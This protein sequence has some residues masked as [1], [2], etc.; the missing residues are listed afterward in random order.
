MGYRD[1]VVVWVSY[2]FVFKDDARLNNL[3]AAR[4]ATLTRG[5]ML[6]RQQ[7]I[8]QTL[9]PDTA[10]GSPLC[11]QQ[12]KHLFNSTR[13]PAI[14][15]DITRDSDMATNGHIIVIRKNRFYVLECF[16]ANGVL[17]STAELETQFRRI[18]DSA[19]ADK[20]P[21]IGLL[22]SENRDSWTRIRTHLL[23]SPKNSASLDVIERAAFV[24]C[25]DDTTPIT[26][27]QASR[28]CW[29]GDGQNRFFDK[30]VQFIVF[31]NAKAGFCGEHSRMEA[32]A[33]SRLCDW[34]VSSIDQGKLDHGSPNSSNLAA[35]LQLSW[36]LNQ[37]SLFAITTAE[38]NFNKL[39]SSQKLHVV[40]YTTYGKSLIKT[41]RVSPDA[42]TQMAIQLAYYK[43]NGRVDA[44]YE[45]AQT[46]KFE[47]GRTETCRSVSIES[48][49]WVMAMGD[50]TLSLEKKCELGKRAIT[51]QSGYM[52]KCAEAH[53]VDRHL[54]GLKL[55]AGKDLPE[56]FKDPAYAK[57]CHWNLSTSQIASEH[58]DGYGWGEVVPDG[59]GC[60]YMVNNASLQFNLTCLVGSGLDPDVFEHYLGEALDEMKAAF[61][62]GTNAVPVIKAKL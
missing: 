30:S 4:A 38:Q 14:P 52:A 36:D 51:A 8:D 7:I 27:D 35:P 20:A 40:R 60:A 62:A 19:G 3:P 41:Y 43:M 18:Y 21:G 10:K 55:L 47:Y 26:R 58:Y 31:D 33:T 6:F 28:E 16:D 17:F 24:V 5:A 56:F 13:I 29:H 53:G 57:S 11:M 12:Y 15:S 23:N 61:D 9:E 34:V 32:T 22:T 42:Y 46:K 48:T 59:W 2:F 1:S 49:E 37:S 45:S 39:V 25:L 50:P 54:L 44:T